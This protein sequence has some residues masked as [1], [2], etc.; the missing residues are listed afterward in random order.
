MA[1]LLETSN[2]SDYD[3]RVIDKGWCLEFLTSFEWSFTFPQAMS[4][5]HDPN[6]RPKLDNKGK[7]V[8]EAENV[9]P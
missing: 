6:K 5:N 4:N 7:A 3:P 8:V 2:L 1:M 9:L